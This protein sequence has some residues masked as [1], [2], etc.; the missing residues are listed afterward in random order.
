MWSSST[1]ICSV[2]GRVTFDRLARMAGRF[3][4]RVAHGDQPGV[5]IGLHRICSRARTALAATDQ[6]VLIVSSVPAWTNR[7]TL[8]AASAVVA[9]A[10]GFDE[11]HADFG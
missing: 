5:R 1:A 9:A 8:I 2:I 6:A 7:G 4:K 10:A 3:L 11:S